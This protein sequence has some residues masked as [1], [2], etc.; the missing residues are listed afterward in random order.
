MVGCLT[1]LLVAICLTS[2]GMPWP[3]ALLLALIAA[4]MIGLFNAVLINE[5]GF[6]P[7]IAT[8]AMASIVQ[9]LTYIVCGTKSIPIKDPAMVAIGT[10]KIGGLIPVTIIFALAAFIIYG[11][12][13]SKTSFGKSIYMI[14]GN[15]RAAKLSG[16]NPKK[17]SYILFIN[18]A[19]L[20]GFAGCLLAFRLKSG[21]V[22]AVAN[23]QFAGLTGAILGGVSFGGGS[24]GMGGAFIGLLLLNG[25]SNG[26]T[27][28]GVPAF[29]QTFGNGALLLIALTFDYFGKRRQLNTKLAPTNGVAQKMSVTTGNRGGGHRGT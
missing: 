15:P 28:L 29:W 17:M 19:V 20:G 10:F 5:F 21:A 13:L 18:N 23:S 2:L 25:F 3:L 27:V 22:D 14:G 26:L 24:G 6:Q 4:G 8:M 12:I 9:G 16:M 1:N 7:F 11:I